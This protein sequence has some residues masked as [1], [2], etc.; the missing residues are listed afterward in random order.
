MNMSS[1]YAFSTFILMWILLLLA[2]PSFVARAGFG[3]RA[4]WFGASAGFLVLFLVFYYGGPWTSNFLGLDPE[5]V[6][7][8]GLVDG[9]FA[10]AAIA[11]AIGGCFYKPRP[12]KRGILG[13]P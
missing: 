4:I 5:D 3:R 10:F 7:W 8:I 12:K 6:D 9:L 1:G 2:T 11:L 13:K